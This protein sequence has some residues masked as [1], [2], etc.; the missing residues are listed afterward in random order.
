MSDAYVKLTDSIIPTAYAQYSFEE[1]VQN[2]D[3]FQAGILYSD[4]SVSAKLSMGGRV[5]EMPSWKDLGGD[6]SEPVN[7][8]PTDSIETKKIGTIQESAPRNIRA[9]A[10]GI[11]DLTAV[12]AGDDPQKIIVQRQTSYWQRAHKATVL[13]MLTGV[14]ADNIANDS[15]DLVF[16]SNASITDTDLIDAAYIMGDRADEFKSVWMHSKQML[17]LR[18]ADLIDMMPA[19][20]QGG[21]LLPYYQGLRVIVDDDIPVSTS[22]YTA[23][24][25]KQN[26]L[27]WNELPVDTEGGP[28]EIDRKPRQAHGGGVT[29]LVTRRHYVVHVP[30]TRYL[31]GSVAGQFPTDAELALAANWNRVA[32]S[33][34]SMTFVGIRTTEA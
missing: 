3:I 18:K 34:K 1:H 12:I 31:A 29:E 5:V 15:A 4:P 2:L 27:M 6:A 22:E 20:Q 26:A 10:W 11:P 17:A 14:L 24:M 19:S 9:Q 16:D 21:M 28:L 13:K 33:K 7:D 8:D 25:F 23:F 32:T 30:G